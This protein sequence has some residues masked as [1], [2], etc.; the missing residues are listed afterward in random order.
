EQPGLL[1]VEGVTP[2]LVQG[3]FAAAAEFYRAEPWV[4]L[5]NSQTFALRFPAK[6]GPEWVVSVMGN[7]GVEYGLSVYKSWVMFEKTFLGAD[8]PLDVLDPQGSLVM[9]YEKVSALP[10]DDYEAIQQQGW[11]VADEQAYPLPIVFKPGDEDNVRRPAAAE[12]RWLEAALRAIV[13]FVRDH[14]RPDGA[15]DYAPAEVTLTVP[16]HKGEKQVRARYPGGELP[17]GSQAAQPAPWEDGFEDEAAEDDD[18]VPPIDRRMMEGMMAQLVSQ[19]G[20]EASPDDPKL[21]KAQKLM[22]KAWEETNPAKR[23]SLAHKA[24]ATSPDCA[25]AYVLLA[26]EEADT[27]ARAAELYRQG[28]EAGAHALGP[29]Y[30]KHEAGHF[31]GLLETRPYMRAREGLAR[32]LWGLNRHD[33]AI[34]H[35]HALLELNPDDNQDVRYS[36]LDLLLATEREAEAALLLKR[37]KDDGMAE[38]LYTWALV[39]FRQNGP[40]K[41]AER[42]LKAAL[43]QNKHVPIYLTGKKRVPNSL[44][45][46]VGWGDDAEAAHYA[47][48]YLHHWRRT[49]GAVEWLKGK[50]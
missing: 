33:E 47:A 17:L 21:R 15:G 37:Y 46:Y 36:L 5:N 14:L 44:P 38:W 9:F 11:E 6:G 3:L 10:F 2:E 43:K 27:L 29:D 22:Y 25:D 49:P 50:R 8:S 24:L 18:D 39:E 19:I 16:T 20:G 31:W 7:G 48:R 34:D 40:G 45:A 28:M 41:T 35:Y 12:L 42:R 32:C 4:K 13:I 26:E 1:S 23:L 30:F